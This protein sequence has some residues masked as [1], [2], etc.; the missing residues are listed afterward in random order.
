MGGARL[1]YAG[2]LAALGTALC[3][4]AGSNFFAAAGRSMGSLVLNRLRIA[5]ALVFLGAAL[6]ITQGSPWPIGATREQVGLLALSGFIGFVFGDTAYFR[7]LVILGPGRAS[8]VASLGPA[9]TALLAIPVLGEHLGPLAWLGMAMTLAGIT[10]VLQER[11]HGAPDH[12]E[13]SWMVGVGAGILGALGQSGGYV[14]SKLALRTGIEPLPATVI[15]VAAAAVAIWAI[16]A[17]QGAVRPTFAA[18]RDR[19]AAGF[20]AA[21]AALGPFAG[22]TLS[23]TALKHIEAGVAASITA[24]YP[25]FTILIASRVHHEKLTWRTLVGAGVAVA[26]VVVLFLR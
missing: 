23:L 9:M 17:A 7:A 16:A 12:V 1:R 4:S 19:R 21:G 3:W 11:R 8:L 13:G 22:V 18:L 5:L 15:R 25:I 24:I 10:W 26:G 14:I 20:M 2:E 6:W